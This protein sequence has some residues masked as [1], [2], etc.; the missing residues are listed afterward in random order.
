MYIFYDKF[1]VLEDERAGARR[2]R[3]INSLA[4]S[5]RDFFKILEVTE[6]TAERNVS[7]PE[8]LIPATIV[9]EGLYHCF[10]VLG[11]VLLLLISHLDIVFDPELLTETLLCNLL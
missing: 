4:A 5:D 10:V 3:L 9:R 11:T 6:D 8:E 7:S 2:L 1:T